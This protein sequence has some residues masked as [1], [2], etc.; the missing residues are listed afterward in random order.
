MVRSEGAPLRSVVVCPPGEEYSAPVD[1]KS[2]NIPS[3]PDA[4]TAA[5][6]HRA[7]R[8]LL[9]E[10][11]V[12]VHSLP[13]LV[14]H[15]NSVFTRDA[16]LVVD[17]GYVR[18]RMGLESRRGE[19]GWISAFLDE[20]GLE[21]VGRIGVNGSADRAGTVE[22]GDVILAGDIAFLGR[23][24][25]SNAEGL[26]QLWGVLGR[27]GY[28]VRVA[29]I[30]PRF[31]HIGGAMSLVGERTV[32]ACRGVFPTGFFRGFEVI[33]IPGEGSGAAGANVICLGE[34]RVV[35]HTGDDPRAAAAL[36]RAGV[37]VIPLDLSEFRKGDGGPTCLILPVERG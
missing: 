22:G 21:E 15:P 20:L 8:D 27:L 35:A 3:P 2:H 1:R 16:V 37:R 11:G 25:R 36:D 4:E 24:E 31:M 30:D 26:R 6:Q 12:R 13:E 17:R 32:I 9:E 18:L 34:G 19:E 23:S 14:G 10:E 7:L 29:E 33:E 5:A 28:E